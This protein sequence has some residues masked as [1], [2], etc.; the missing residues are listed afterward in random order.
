[1][2]LPDVFFSFYFKITHSTSCNSCKRVYQSETTQLYVELPVPP[3]NSSLNDYIEEYFNTGSLV[4]KFCE[5][6]CKNF[7]QAEK[8]SRL[9]LASE[10]EFI[11]VILSRAIETIDG[12][13]LVE[14]KLLQQMIYLS[15]STKHI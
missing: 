9:R 3:N 6:G 11:I 15:G 12:F 8:R 10:T 14:T 7:I 4:G 1:M 2:S 5:D 13:E